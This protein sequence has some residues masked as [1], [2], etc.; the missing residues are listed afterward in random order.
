MEKLEEGHRP[1]D[2]NETGFQE[3]KI[4]KL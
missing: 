1:E 2:Y 4:S 3:W